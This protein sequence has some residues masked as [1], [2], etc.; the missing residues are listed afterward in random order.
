LL[1][2]RLRVAG[3]NTPAYYS[4]TRFG[5]IYAIQPIK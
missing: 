1:P 4:A 3:S 2:A 5:A